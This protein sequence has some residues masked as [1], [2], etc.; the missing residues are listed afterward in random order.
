M[1]GPQLI[2]RSAITSPTF[3]KQPLRLYAIAVRYGWEEEAKLASKY[4]LALSLHDNE[5]SRILERIP[6]TYVL[7]LFHLHRTRRDKFKSHVTRDNG[8]FGIQNCPSCYRSLRNSTLG[9]LT[10]FIVW[11]MDR[12]PD[13]H[14]LLE[15][16]WKE[17]PGYE[18]DKACSHCSVTFS[19]ARYVERISAD[20]RS[21]LQSLPSTI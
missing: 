7:R 16:Q 20:I 19:D 14:T 10:N 3:L 6:T 21:C 13:G 18:G 8:C 9:D 2:I 15:G 5:H 17:W 12:Y 1:L 4:S 11:E